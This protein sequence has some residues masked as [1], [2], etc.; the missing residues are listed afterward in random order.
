MDC[1]EC[2]FNMS[3]TRD[4]K[5]GRMGRWWSGIK[6]KLG[7]LFLELGRPL[8]AISARV[9]FWSGP[10]HCHTRIIR[11]NESSKP[12]SVPLGPWCIVLNNHLEALQPD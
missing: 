2:R 8:P 9:T 1:G 4:K 6:L 12:P 11:S 5:R 3:R 7:E 10:T